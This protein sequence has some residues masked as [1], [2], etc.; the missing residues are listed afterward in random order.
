[1]KFPNKATS[2]NESIMPCLLK[3]IKI[4]SF[5]PIDIMTLKKELNIKDISLFA[6]ALSCLYALNKI[7]FN[8]N[9][10]LELC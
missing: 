8:D 4:I 5:H 7:K 9:K 2:I 6:D 1:M 10:E 3:L